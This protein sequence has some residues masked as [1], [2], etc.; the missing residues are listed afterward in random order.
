MKIHYQAIRV[1][2][3]CF[4]IL[5]LNGC[6]TTWKHKSTFYKTTQ[7]LLT[8]HSNPSGDVFINNRAA[9]KS[10]LIIPLSYEREFVR[11][12]RK[13]TFWKTKP[14]LAVFLTAVS[15]G[16]YLPFSAIPV[17]VETTFEPTANFRGNEFRVRIAAQGFTDWEDMLLL[18]GQEKDSVQPTLKKI[19]VN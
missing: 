17:D 19:G 5:L 7:T 10:P 6:A 14:G 13:V 3:A 2:F 11:K 8:V 1:T 4:A 12:N 18:S 16:V 9:G 15:L